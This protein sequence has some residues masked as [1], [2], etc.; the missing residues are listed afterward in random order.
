MAITPNTLPP[1]YS[2][3]N[4]SQNNIPNIEA[5]QGKM[6][7]ANLVVSEMQILSHNSPNSFE[8]EVKQRLIMLLLQE[9]VRNKSV[10]FTKRID[11]VTLDHAY[12]ARIFVVPDDKVRIL[13]LNGA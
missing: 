10:E 1:G 4:W 13:R 12:H 6:L 11:S 8:D 7:T 5:V 9:I 2:S 3:T